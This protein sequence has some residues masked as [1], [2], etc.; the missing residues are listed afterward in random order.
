[1]SLLEL[2]RENHG[3]TKQMANASNDVDGFFHAQAPSRCQLCP[4]SVRIKVLVT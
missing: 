3:W 2:I 1:M 4:P